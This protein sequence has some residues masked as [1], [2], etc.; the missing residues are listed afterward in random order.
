MITIINIVINSISKEEELEESVQ[1]EFDPMS[2]LN[3]L[4]N[5]ARDGIH[6]VADG[7]YR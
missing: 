6:G 3:P 5:K 1:E 4:K 2:Y 7:I